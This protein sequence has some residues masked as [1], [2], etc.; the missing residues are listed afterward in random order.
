DK[1]VGRLLLND[2]FPRSGRALLVSGR[3]SFEIV[4]KAAMARFEL[5]LGI[6][7]PS[8]LAIATAQRLGITLLGFSRSD[9]YNVYS[10]E[11]RLVASQPDP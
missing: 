11:E 8:S 4:Q 10:G 1:V 2:E 6:S 3:T 9:G 5:V 7:A